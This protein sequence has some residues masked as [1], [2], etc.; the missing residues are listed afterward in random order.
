MLDTELFFAGY[1]QYNRRSGE[2]A[3]LSHACETAR[4]R[5]LFLPHTFHE[6]RLIQAL[7]V[8]LAM[9]I[10]ATVPS[11]LQAGIQVLQVVSAGDW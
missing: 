1:W 10:V 11:S 6:P 7:L 5:S 3:S 4:A 9:L 2:Y 8:V